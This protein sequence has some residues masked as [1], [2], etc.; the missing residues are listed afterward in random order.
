MWL[1]LGGGMEPDDQGWEAI[2]QSLRHDP[3]LEQWVHLTRSVDDMTMQLLSGQ[4]Q[5]TGNLKWRTWLR[6]GTAKSKN[7]QSWVEAVWEWWEGQNK[8]EDRKCTIDGMERRTNIQEVMNRVTQTHFQAFS[9]KKIPYEWGRFRA[10]L[11]KHKVFDK[12]GSV[13]KK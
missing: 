13:W 8:G 9:V 12:V 2:I 5:G 3:T 7:Q 1:D 11:Y 6:R 10:E 4:T